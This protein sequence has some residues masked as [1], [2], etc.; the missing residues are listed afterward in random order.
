MS[1]LFLIGGVPRV[2]VERQLSRCGH[3]FDRTLILEAID[4]LLVRLYTDRLSACSLESPNKWNYEEGI[5]LVIYK[6][7]TSISSE[8]DVNEILN[9]FFPCFNIIAIEEELDTTRLDRVLLDLKAETFKCHDKI[10]RM[11]HWMYYDENRDGCSSKIYSMMGQLQ[12]LQEKAQQNHRHSIPRIVR[13]IDFL[14]LLELPYDDDK[15]HYWDVIST[16]AFQPHSLTTGELI[17]CAFIL[18]K[19]LSE[20]AKLGISDNKLL[21]LLFTL[22][23][24]YHQVNKFHNFKHA[25]DVMQ[26]TW[27][28]CEHLM[29]D[30]LPVLLLSMAAIG[31]DMGHPG[32]N[33]QL[34]CQYDSPV[35]IYYGKKSVLENMHTDLFQDLLLAHWPQ[36]LSNQHTKKFHSD[37]NIISEA[38][39]STDMALHAEYVEKLKEKTEMTDYKTLISLIIK[40][41][42]ISN[43]TRPLTISSQWACLITFEFNDCDVLE[44]LEAKEPNNVEV[45]SPDHNPTVEDRIESVED[46]EIYRCI[47]HVSFLSP[48]DLVAKYPYIPKCQIFFID[49]FAEQFFTEF[50]DK[51]PTVKF[52]A[53]N[54]RKNKKFWLSKDSKAIKHK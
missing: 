30:P 15:E 53:E 27:Q 1:T 10:S 22:E 5:S 45:H 19:K 8:K 39:M 33:N 41:A 12:Q 3:L 2:Q 17:Y 50:C 49:T 43:V 13:N 4:D 48:D 26:A 29:N 7:V 37:F 6:R 44:K 31:H 25:V 11:A 24:S 51:F 18:L 42:D 14:S 16:W 35:A 21:L 52:L 32:S 20:D 46:Q 54:I 38:I 47:S 23:A 36:L 34:L 40:A 28:L 9:S